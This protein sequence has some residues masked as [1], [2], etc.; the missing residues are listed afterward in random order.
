VRDQN[1]ECSLWSLRVAAYKHS[2]D[3]TGISQRLWCCQMR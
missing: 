3:R 1:L 2:P